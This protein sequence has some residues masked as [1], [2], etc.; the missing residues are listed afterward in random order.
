MGKASLYVSGTY[1]GEAMLTPSTTEDTMS[2]SLGTDRDVV[3]ERN[4]MKD[5][6]RSQ[7]VGSRTV[8]Q[9]GYEI[10]LKNNKAVAV[11]LEVVDQI[12]VS[13]TKDVEVR[14]MESTGQNTMPRKA[15][16]HGRW[17]LLRGESRT[18]VL[19]YEVRHPQYL[20]VT[21]E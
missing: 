17:T 12:P 18:L 14:L 13:T 6:R 8:Q 21:L 1:I 20:S 11:K 19:K 5:F 10:K 7:T 15:S 3:I 4:L 2:I 9:R 16:S